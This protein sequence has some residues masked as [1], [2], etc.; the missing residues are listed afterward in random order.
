[1]ASVKCFKCGRVNSN[2]NITCESCG[3][4]LHG[5]QEYEEK[6]QELKDYEEFRKRYSI[7][8]IILA[9][10]VLLLLCPAVKWLFRVVYPML[11]TEILP[12]VILEYAAP[13][14]ILLV[15]LI[16]VLPMILGRWKIR[17]RYRWTKERMRGLNREVKSLPKDFFG[18]A[19][20]ESDEVV[21]PVRKIQGPPIIL[22]II[23]FTLVGLVYVNKYTDIKPLDSITSSFGIENAQTVKGKYDSHVNAKNLGGGVMR[24]EQTWSYV[25]HS[26][27]TYTSYLEGYQQYSGTWSQSGNIL[28]V[29]VPAIANISA[30]YSFQATVS[31]DGNSFTSGERKFIKVK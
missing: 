25:F 3:E 20:Q 14:L 17:R 11:G 5:G 6:F 27:G 29:N 9:I 23:V 24:S 28:T 22:L 26:D 8:G 21:A 18:T 2:E 12:D 13:A 31:R 15:F 19:M 16:A 1:M 10:L 7:L 30:A 4:K